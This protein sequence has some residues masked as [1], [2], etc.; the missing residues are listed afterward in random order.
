LEVYAREFGDPQNPTQSTLGAGG[1]DRFLSVLG[2][3]FGRRLLDEAEAPPTGVISWRIFP[4]LYPQTPRAE[5]RTLELE[6]LAAQT[7]LTF[8]EEQRDVRELRVE[9]DK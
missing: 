4:Y 1:F 9:R 6:H 2:T 8:R 5:D 3:H 7:G